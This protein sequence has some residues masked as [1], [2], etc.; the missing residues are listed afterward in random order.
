MSTACYPVA[1]VDVGKNTMHIVVLDQAGVVAH[2]ARGT[3]GHGVTESTGSGLVFC[4][5]WE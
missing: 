2:K 3:R 4:Y 1:G 5:P